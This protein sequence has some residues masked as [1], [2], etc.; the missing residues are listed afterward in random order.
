MLESYGEPVPQSP[1]YIARRGWRWSPGARRAD[2]LAVGVE[3]EHDLLARARRAWDGQLLDVDLISGVG[4][5]VVRL[6]IHL[7]R[8]PLGCAV[9]DEPRLAHQSLNS[10]SPL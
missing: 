3:G 2:S 6:E 5:E 9:L 7:P 10:W 1:E 4:E 8:T